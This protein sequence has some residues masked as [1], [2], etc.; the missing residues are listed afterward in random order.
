MTNRL[1]PTVVF[2]HSSNE[3]FG[4]D[5]VLL[6]VVDSVLQSG[7]FRPIV[8]LPDDVEEAEES[9]ARC[10]SDRG[11]E[12]HVMALPILRRRYLTPAHLPRLLARGLHLVWAVRRCKPV[13][14]YCATS[15]VLLA[16]P[17]ARL[18]GVPQVIVHVQ[19]I[20][21][22]KEG[23]VLG[24]LARA[25][26]RAI[27]ISTAVT[28]SLRGPIRRRAQQIT[29]AVSDVQ[30][31]PPAPLA[32]SSQP[33]RFLVASRWN[34][35]KGHR[36]LLEAWNSLPEPPGILTIAGSPP[37]MGLAVDVSGLVSRLDHPHSVVVAG[38]VSSISELLDANDVL[39]VPSDGAEPFGLVAIEAFSRYR[40][41]I[42][43][44]DGGLSEIVTDGVDGVLFANR[45]A[46]E[47]AAVLA[48]F[49]RVSAQAF[50]VAGRAR[51]DCDF[52]MDR[53]REEFAVL[54][55]D[56]E[57]RAVTR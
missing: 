42:A 46:R 1:L 35:W 7:R 29:N 11:V 31:P 16:A 12:C 55:G 37:E 21:E 50:G 25:C 8:W 45:S 14:V 39:I 6:E 4:A 22:G 2:I 38:Q 43:S 36:T 18:A 28:E 53:Y 19:E 56:L 20:W 49:D 13:V 24:A 41:V 5:R 32:E 47:L 33:L 17:A 48:T 40:G 15:A 54:W 44:K 34:S 27:T 51:Y 9:I 26:T 23:V 57:R 52:S 10:L 30:N 3:M